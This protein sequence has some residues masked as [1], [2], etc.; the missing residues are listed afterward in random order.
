MTE[1]H[2]YDLIIVGAGPAGLSAGL[3]AGRATLDTLIIEGDT[4]GGQVTTTSVVYNYPAVEKVDGT[5][6]MNQMQRQVTDFGVAIKHDQIAKYDL[7]GEVKTLTGKSGQTYQARSV[8]IATGANPR[9]V[10]FPGEAEFRGRGIAYCS[11]CDGELFTGLQIFV[12]GGGYAA[13]EEADYLSRFG[14]HVTVLVRGDHF[15][16]PPLTAARALNNP[17]VSVEY[18]TEVKRVDGDDYLTSATLVNN[19]TGEET[20]YH[21][22][23]GDNTFGMFIYIGTQPATKD[24]EGIVELSKDG[25]IKTDEKGA[26]NVPGVYAAGDVIVKP[27]RQIITAAADGATAATTAETYVTAQKQQQ[28][29]PIHAAVDKKPAKTVGQT[30]QLDHQEEVTPHEGNWLTADIDQQLR[31]I[32]DRL[33]KDVTFQ[34]NTNDSELSQQL[35]SF[36][37]EFADLDDHFTV[38]TV[39]GNGNYLP[40]LKLLDGDGDDTGLHYAGIPTGHELNSLVL[41]VYNVAGPGQTIAPEMVDRIKKL[42]P[43]DIRI[44]VS[45]TCHFCP[46]VVAACQHMA[47][48]NPGITATMIDLQHFPALRKEKKIMSVPATMIGDD[49]V[50]FGS[51]SLEEL[52]AA[53]EKHEQQ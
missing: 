4:V 26:T 22:D 17:K 16:C 13:A 12:V 1:Q 10:G 32:F 25:Y 31:P 35:V 41:G 47:A 15:T 38:T 14:K 40:M 11:T 42:G 24:L 28:G 8:I 50:I 3:Y 19:K 39:E 20:V 7:M 29:V 51:Q 27:L 23:K 21:V 53:V 49:P 45:L 44:G 37:T 6:L 43:V 48:L 52:V 2:L 34:V 36:V 5:Q 30:T 33:T 9:K 18:N 46:D